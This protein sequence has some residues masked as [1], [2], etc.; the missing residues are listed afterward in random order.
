MKSLPLVVPLL[1]TVIGLFSAEAEILVRWNFNYP[2]SAD[3]SL[4]DD[5]VL[6]GTNAPCT[7]AGVLSLVGGVVLQATGYDTGDPNCPPC[8]P[9][10]QFTANNP[11][12]GPYTNNSSITITNFP[13]QGTANKTAG[14]EMS[15]STVGYTNISVSWSQRHQ[16]R[17]GRY[18]RLQ[19]SLDGATFQDVPAE[20][21]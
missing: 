19:Y 3:M 4:S 21:G 10:Y 16:Q 15:V 14:Y 2:L 9:F 17:T 18:H 1:S 5:S 12:T 20:R 7:G 11:K 8:D 6:T 13:V